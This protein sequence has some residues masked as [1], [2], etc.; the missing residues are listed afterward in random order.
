MIA[1]RYLIILA[2]AALAA[3]TPE[4]LGPEQ[5]S[6]RLR[7][8]I[9]ADLAVTKSILVDNP[10]VKLESFW[11]AGDQIGVFGGSAENA[12]FSLKAEDLSTDRKTAD[13]STDGTIPGGKLTAYAPYQK[14]A[15]KDGDAIVVTF[16]ARQSYVTYNGVV[17][18]DPAANILLGEGS[19][20]GGLTFR[21]LTAVLKIGQVFEQETLVKSV[22]FRDLSGAAVT[23]A[24]KLTGGTSPKA[25]IT[26]DGKVL[27]LD[28]G[29]GVE[30]AAGSMRPLF[31]VVPA[32][33]YAQGFEITFID[34]KGGKTVR[35]VGATKGKTLERGVVYLIGDISGREYPVESSTTLKEG[36]I[37]MTPEILDKVE[38]VVADDA[39]VRDEDGNVINNEHNVA[40]H[41]PVF[42]LV[43]PKDL[44]PVEGGWLI[45]DQPSAALPEG[46]IYK[47]TSCQPVGNDR[48]QVEA[49][50]EPNFAAPF[51]DLTVGEATLDENGI[52]SD[53]GG[54]ELDLAS[55]LASVIDSEGNPVP[56]S[57][58]PDGQILFSEEST[59]SLLN[60]ALPMTKGPMN[61]TF[62]APKLTFKHSEKNAEVAFGAQLVLNTTLAIKILHGELQLIYFK[63]NPVFTLSADFALKAEMNGDWPFHL[64]TLQFVPITVAPGFIVTPQLKLS[65]KLGLGG[66]LKFS[67]SVSYEYDMGNYCLA[68]NK[69]DGFT[70]RHLPPKPS[71]VEL[72]PSLGGYSGS[73]YA[74][75]GLT[76]S[77]YLSIY[78]MLGMGADIDFV[79]KFGLGFEQ[80]MDAVYPTAHK[81]FLTPEINI[82]PSIASL[83]GYFTHKFS[84]LTTNLE[85]DPIWERYLTPVVME[86]DVTEPIGPTR[87]MEGTKYRTYDK[88]EYD[89]DIIHSYYTQSQ[90]FN[91]TSTICTQVEGFQYNLVSTKPTLDPW[92]VKLEV[93]TGETNRTW[94]QLALAHL[95]GGG[96]GYWQY[97]QGEKLTYTGVHAVAEY[98]MMLISSGIEEQKKSGTVG[99]KADFP[100][101]KVRS[102]RIIYV[103]MATG[104]TIGREVGMDGEPVYK[105]LP[106]A[107]YWPETP[108]G[109]YFVSIPMSYSNWNSYNDCPLPVG[110][111]STLQ[112]PDGYYGP[113][114]GENGE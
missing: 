79:L 51:E 3:C 14:E 107:T 83:G 101:G 80:N 77:P 8:V 16:P 21:N 114:E 40:I 97:T 46:G 24:M 91:G 92:A 32:R 81:L 106:F 87:S 73:L 18:P 55:H 4:G 17:Q 12:L 42:S 93:M 111:P 86:V 78:G 109:P 95:L 69:G 54:I 85:F 25:E 65:G 11:E 102:F 58:T 67:A 35:T 22:E 75:A 82:T 76:A 52:L 45:F 71:K 103:N 68:Y 37:L 53:E 113:K 64:I 90:F 29:E 39:W 7:G 89:N 41:R 72:K 27:T 5:R 36:A 94:A 23:G 48:Y 59:E 50:F 6:D 33:A 20:A 108:D 110:T 61:K 84:D 105:G 96:G 19:K 99:S 112:E 63:A 31:L 9:D 56:F 43:V 38:I 62:T 74:S 2:A 13:F 10:G 1:T 88:D 104:E 57:V 26:G 70:A 98:E 15:K 47:I 60:N 49:R 44:N 34:D 100:E 66:E 30:F 28:M